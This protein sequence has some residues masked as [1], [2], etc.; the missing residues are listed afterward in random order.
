MQNKGN[1]NNR[2]NNYYNN[3]FLLKYLQQHLRNKRESDHLEVKN[4]KRKILKPQVFPNEH[5]LKEGK[6]TI[7][8]R[9]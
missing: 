6:M 2:K 1:H 9:N 8:R 4:Q 7:H 3:K 5:N